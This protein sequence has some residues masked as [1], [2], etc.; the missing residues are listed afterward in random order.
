MSICIH[1][2][3]EDYQ[4]EWPFVTMDVTIVSAQGLRS[5]TN[6]FS[7][8]GIRPFTTLST[9]ING[10]KHLHVYRT[11]VD[12]Y[13]GAN[14]AW[15]DKFQLPVDEA[16]FNY[17]NVISSY[18]Y[19]EVFTKRLVAGQS[20]LGWCQI[21]VTDIVNEFFP[22]D[23]VRQLSYQLRNR[24]GSRGQGVV[25]IEVKLT[26]LFHERF[27]RPQRPLI[28]SGGL[29]QQYVPETVIGIPVNQSD[30]NEFLPVINMHKQ[31]PV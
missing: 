22:K 21:P 1:R 7:S 24:D 20:T 10:V 8:R 5:R 23:G 14:P 26:G 27:Q 4:I 18:I 16:T 28:C 25:N 15:G 19:L 11:K 6:L 12:N 2:M 9:N 31:H 29:P 13:G 3:Q 17:S 30:G